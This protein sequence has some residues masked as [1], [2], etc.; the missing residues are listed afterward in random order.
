MREFI[1][2]SALL[3][4]GLKSISSE[5]LKQELDKKWEIA[6][7]D[8]GQT[9][10][11]NV[12]EFCEFRERAADYG[13]VNYF[14][15]EQAVHE[16]RSGALTASGT[17]RVCEDR[18]I[19]LVVTCGIGGLVSD[20]SVEKCNDLRAL[21]QSEVSML[22]TSFKDMFDFSY[23]VEQAEKAGIRICVSDEA[24]P[25][26]YVFRHQRVSGTGLP[27]VKAVTPHMLWLN[28]IPA[29]KRIQDYRILEEAVIYGKEQEKQGRYFHPAVNA[30]IDELTGG[31]S[32]EIQLESLIANAHFAEDI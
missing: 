14:N 9:I 6:W 7:L 27:A 13:R 18:K 21:M 31:R 20:Q 30:R 17:M 3:T 22:A 15:Y 2:E 25:E 29:E 26:G 12:N 16:S 24:L 23:T 10:V 4:H 8:H 1:I 5:R 19:P 11:G 32:S 28:P